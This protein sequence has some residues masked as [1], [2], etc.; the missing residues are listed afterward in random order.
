MKKSRCTAV[1]VFS[2]FVA[3]T[4]AYGDVIYD[5]SGS[6]TDGCTGSVTGVLVLADTYAP[7]TLLEDSH[8][9]SWS[10]TSSTQSYTVPGDFGFKETEG[11]IL[12][13]TAGKEAFNSGSSNR[14]IDYTG[15][16]TYQIFYSTSWGSQTPAQLDW[17]TGSRWTLRAGVPEPTTIALMGLG[18]AGIGLRRR[19]IKAK[20]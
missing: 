12:P 20:R 6:C 3:S 5:W 16:A 13:V 14:W 4:N 10:Y 2:V 18:L 11:L 17:G 8:F 9:L 19:K 7:G 15:G 1:L